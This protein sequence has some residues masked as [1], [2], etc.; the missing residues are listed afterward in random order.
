MALDAGYRHIDTAFAY[1]NEPG[2][3]EGIRLSGVKREDIFVTTK[4]WVT[5]RG[6]EKT[7]KTVEASLKNLGM[8]YMDLYLVHWPCVEKVSP[9]WKEINAETWRGFERMYQDGKIRALGVSNYEK[10]HLD[11]LWE[12]ATIKPMVNQLEFHP[13][14][15]QPEIVSYCKEHGVLVEAWSPLGTGRVLGNETLCAIAQK[16]G[17][18]TAQ[19]CIRWCLQHDTL[20]LPKSVTPSRIEENTRVFDFSISDEDM[21]AIDALPYIGGSGFHPDRVDF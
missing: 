4:H 19:L 3:G 21:A 6:Y 1:G 12:T 13:G 9:E 17:V 7:I 14:Y 8:D 2:V 11:P 20:P 5:E 18:S 16:Y 10:K 15:M